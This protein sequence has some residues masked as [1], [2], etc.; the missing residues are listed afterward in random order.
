MNTDSSRSHSVFTLIITSEWCE[1]GDKIK[2]TAR[3]NVV[4][5]AGCERLNNTEATGKRIKEAIEINRFVF[6]L[7]FIHFS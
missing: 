3:L 2:R 4:D 5:L 1:N 7:I 6:K